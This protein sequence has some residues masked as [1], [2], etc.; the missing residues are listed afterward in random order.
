MCRKILNCVVGFFFNSVGY[1][2]ICKVLVGFLNIGTSVSE[3]CICV[4][5]YSYLM[6]QAIY[7]G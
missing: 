7:R 2:L 5:E 6:F 3:K 4:R 1:G